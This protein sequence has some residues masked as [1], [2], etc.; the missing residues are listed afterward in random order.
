VLENDELCQLIRSRLSVTDDLKVATNQVLDVCL[1]RGSRD[2]M[3]MIL[4]VFDAAPKPNPELIEKEKEW[5]AKV[6]AKIEG[7]DKMIDHVVFVKT[8]FRTC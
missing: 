4:V 3:T 5:F 1:S 8:L 2:N 6:E 7:T